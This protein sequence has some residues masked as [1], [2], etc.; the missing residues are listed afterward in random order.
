MT[1]S[2]TKKQNRGGEEEECS[3]CINA[4]VCHML[5]AHFTHITL[6]LLLNIIKQHVT[7]A[8]KTS[9]H[10]SLQLY[11]TTDVSDNAQLIA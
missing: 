4:S 3:E 9:T 2:T 1:V 8:I 6:Y 7:A 5:E 11:E 10:F